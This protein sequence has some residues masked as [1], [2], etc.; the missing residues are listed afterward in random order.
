MVVPQHQE[1]SGQEQMKKYGLI[2]LV[3][4]LG[5]ILGTS[6][7]PLRAQTSA[8]EA[9]ASDCYVGESSSA[10]CAGK[11]I[12]FAGNTHSLDESV[13]VLR[14][15]SETGEVWYK[16]GKRFQQIQESN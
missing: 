16:D 6:I 5:V 12:F 4:V 15:N 14:I 13:W 3:L 10:A 7:S 11:W 8:A 9:E 2:G 1:Q